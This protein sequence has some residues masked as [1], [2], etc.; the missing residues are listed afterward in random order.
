M[1]WIEFWDTVSVFQVVG[2]IL[3]ILGIIGFIAK[4]WP[5][6]KAA[7]RLVDALSVLPDFIARTDTTLEEQ[8]VKIESIHHE[9]HHNNGSSLKDAQKRTE[10]AVERIELG[11]RGLYDRAD[12]ADERAD[13]ADAADAAATLAM[14]ELREDL[15]HTR[16]AVVKRRPA[17]STK[18]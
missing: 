11:V 14:E 13:A 15:E 10:E 18:E 2:W 7:V 8:N 12:A 6:V 1:T 5:K 9:T 4:G 3:G 17:K 16:P